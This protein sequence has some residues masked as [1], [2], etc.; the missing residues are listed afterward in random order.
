MVFAGMC[1]KSLDSTTCAPHGTTL[2]CKNCY[3]RA[4]GPKGYGFASGAAGL[5]TNAA[6]VR[7]CVCVCVCMCVCLSVCLSVCLPV[8]LSVCAR[9]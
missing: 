1:K 8:F 2:Y 7:V 3:G 5:S 4:H 6:D 9:T